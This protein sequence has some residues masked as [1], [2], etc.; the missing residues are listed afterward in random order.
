MTE[1]QNPATFNLDDWALDAGLPEESAD[2]FKRANVVSELSAL[3]RQIALHREAAG[4]EKTAV[5]D[6]ELAAL[7]FKYSELVETF[8]NSLMTVY[9]RAITS[10][11]REALRVSHEERCKNWDPQR[12]NREYGFDLLAAAITAVRPIG[13]ERTDVSWDVHQVKKLE[14]AIGASQMS[15][16]LAAREVAQ[17]HAPTVDA[18]FLQKP[19]GSETGQD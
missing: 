11:E 1:T 4:V 9:V 10:D 19:S 17:N 5:G 2:V 13:G 12:R 16:I 15:L 8:G 6:S 18:D 7:E 3:K 14:A